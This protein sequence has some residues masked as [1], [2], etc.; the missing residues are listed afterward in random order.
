MDTNYGCQ[1]I[2]VKELFDAAASAPRDSHTFLTERWVWSSIRGT[3]PVLEFVGNL[4]G[5]GVCYPAL[6]NGI[7][8]IEGILLTSATFGRVADRARSVCEEHLLDYQMDRFGTLLTIIIG[9]EG[10]GQPK[11]E[12]FLFTSKC[13][14]SA[15]I[16]FSIELQDQRKWHTKPLLET[17]REL[18]TLGNRMIDYK[19]IQLDGR[20]SCVIRFGEL[21][22]MHDALGRIGRKLTHAGWSPAAAIACDSRSF[23]VE[24]A[25]FRKGRYQASIRMV[26][27]DITGDDLVVF[28]RVADETE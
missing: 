12:L 23:G 10:T 1:E 24:A 16:K 20:R 6:K 8:T 11:R 27:S 21:A 13:G 17:F 9:G 5:R 3:D 15:G 14:E 26:G 4:R 22:P 19:E 2:S 7:S 28:C 18:R 25:A